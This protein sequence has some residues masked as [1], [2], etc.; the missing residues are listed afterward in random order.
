ME[1]RRRTDLFDGKSPTDERTR[2]AIL[3][4][5]PFR[6]SLENPSPHW[7]RALSED[8]L[9]RESVEE[10]QDYSQLHWMLGGPWDDCS[11]VEYREALLGELDDSLYPWLGTYDEGHESYDEGHKKEAVAMAVLTCSY[12]YGSAGQVWLPCVARTI[13]LSDLH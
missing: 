4:L 13:C 6:L 8:Y 9:S 5:R 2:L 11:E 12:V 1:E 7:W 3:G 10:L